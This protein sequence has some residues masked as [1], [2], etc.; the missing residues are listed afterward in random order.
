MKIRGIILAGG[1]SS[2]MGKNKLELEIEGRPIIDRVIDNAKRSKLDDIVV[3]WGKYDVDTDIPKLFNERFEEG[4]S[5]SIIKGMKNF[6]GD[7][8]MILLGDMPFIE[9]KIIDKLICSYRKSG[10]NIAI[11]V[12][13]GRKGNPVIIGNKYF[14]DLLKNRG[15]KGARCIIAEN[16]QDVELVEIGSEAIFLDID[17]EQVYKKIIG[18]EEG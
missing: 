3:I 16:L 14:N 7:A 15:D 9:S 5:T 8:V 10:K 1:K 11:P 12:C 13:E 6:D 4:M 18:N 17:N 2:R